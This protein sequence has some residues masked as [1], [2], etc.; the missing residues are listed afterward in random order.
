M[1]TYP[2]YHGTPIMSLIIMPGGY[3]MDLLFFG[4]DFNLL[5]LELRILILLQVFTNHIIEKWFIGHM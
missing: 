3:I 1:D 2:H 4:M 5:D